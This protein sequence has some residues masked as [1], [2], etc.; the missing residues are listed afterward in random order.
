MEEYESSLEVAILVL[1]SAEHDKFIEGR[2][3]V[4]GELE[5]ERIQEHRDSGS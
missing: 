1:Q 4:D 5:G 3:M 2:Q